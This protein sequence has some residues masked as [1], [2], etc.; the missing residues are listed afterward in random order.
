MIT[1]AIARQATGDQPHC[2]IID[3]INSPVTN[4]AMHGIVR[5]D[6]KACVDELQQNK[7]ASNVN[8]PGALTARQLDLPAAV[9]KQHAPGCNQAQGNAYALH[10]IARWP[11]KI[12]KDIPEG[13]AGYDVFC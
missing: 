7:C 2:N 4:G 6:E 1:C 5:G 3:L 9:V 12:D 10:I 11:E 13:N 8:P